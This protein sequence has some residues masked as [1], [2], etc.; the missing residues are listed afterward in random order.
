MIE[1]ETDWIATLC[2]FAQTPP[3][4]GL[5]L[6]FELK[7]R[8]PE[9]MEVSSAVPVYRPHNALSPSISRTSEHDIAS[10]VGRSKVS[11]L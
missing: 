5:E 10:E 4:I 1:L 2:G 3:E 8:G 9:A 11:K 6:F 7:L